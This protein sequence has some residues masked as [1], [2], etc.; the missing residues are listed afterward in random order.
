[1]FACDGL[2]EGNKP[3][4]DEAMTRWCFMQVLFYGDPPQTDIGAVNTI[5]YFA[6][7]RNA[8]GSLVSVMHCG[9]HSYSLAFPV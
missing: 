1:M 7:P 3:L 8:Q 6:E 9:M 4:H 5:N 2:D